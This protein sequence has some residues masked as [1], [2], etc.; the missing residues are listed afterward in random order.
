M[1]AS[2]IGSLVVSCAV[3]FTLTATAQDKP[4]PEGKKPAAK[5]HSMTGC[6]EKGA[7][8]DSFVVSN[9][10]PKGPKTIAIVESKENLA[11]HV[12]HKVTITGVDIPAK[13]AESAKS[14]PAKADHYMRV[15]AVKMVAATCP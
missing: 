15:S 1:R 11:P 5:E 13:E 3:A 8:P 10:E 14:K 6:V 2:I 12:G 9:T 4:A 7:T